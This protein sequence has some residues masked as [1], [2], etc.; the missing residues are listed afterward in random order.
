MPND[1]DL[2]RGEGRSLAQL[3]GTR[4]CIQVKLELQRIHRVVVAQAGAACNRESDWSGQARID[5][6]E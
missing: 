2:A 3:V 6:L 4:Q 5:E 1:E